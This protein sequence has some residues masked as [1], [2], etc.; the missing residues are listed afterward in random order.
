MGG[1][2]DVAPQGVDAGEIDEVETS[3]GVDDDVPAVG[4]EVGG[5]GPPEPLRCAG[6]DGDRHWIGSFPWW[7]WCRQ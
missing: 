1:V 5:D 7:G 2:G 6:D 3:A 4:G